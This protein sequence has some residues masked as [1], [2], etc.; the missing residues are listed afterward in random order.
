MFNFYYGD[1][2]DNQ[3]KRDLFAEIKSKYFLNNVKIIDDKWS[4][5]FNGWD[6]SYCPP[7]LNWN[8]N[9]IASFS[10]VIFT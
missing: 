9:N 3:G 1:L 4:C 8:Q 5:F 7:F 10:V 6:M 2:F